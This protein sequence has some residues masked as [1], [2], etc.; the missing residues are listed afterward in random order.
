MWTR[1]FIADA[2]TLGSISIPANICVGKTAFININYRVISQVVR[3][4]YLHISIANIANFC[5]RLMN[6]MVVMR[7]RFLDPLERN[8]LDATVKVLRFWPIWEDNHWWKF[9]YAPC[10]YFS[11]HFSGFW[12]GRTTIP[13]S[14][15][16]ACHSPLLR[17][18]RR[19]KPPVPWTSVPRSTQQ[20]T[21]ARIFIQGREWQ[22]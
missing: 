7:S 11:R 19:R 13:K 2:D 6:R 16:K 17:K 10:V 5:E 22:K 14:F 3:R 1:Y 9:S 21:K 12:S 18:P 15:T 4:D 20:K 8:R